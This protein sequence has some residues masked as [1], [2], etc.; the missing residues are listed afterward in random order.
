MSPTQRVVLAILAAT[1]AAA[2]LV[3][4][5]PATAAPRHRA[6]TTARYIVVLRDGSDAG[7]VSAEQAQHVG[8]HVSYVYRRVVNGYAAT[9]RPAQA[10]RLARDPRV[11]SV[12]RDQR[13]RAR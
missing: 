3:T 8:T 12:E 4:A 1:L 10:R 13:V 9:M 5:S 11:E 6:R 7:A 2:A